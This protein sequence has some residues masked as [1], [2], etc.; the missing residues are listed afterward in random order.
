LSDEPTRALDPALALLEFDSIALGIVAADAMVKASPIGTIYGGTVQPGKYLVLISGDTASVEEALAVGIDRGGG[1]LVDSMFLPD[2]HPAVTA[3]VVSAVPGADF[4]GEALGI[5]ETSTVAAV[6]ASS[7]AGVKA[8]AV[9][10]IAVRMAD[11][12][13]GKGYALYSGPIAEVEAALEAASA[14]AG[15]GGALLRGEIV[16]QLHDEIAL[17]LAAELRFGPRVR[18]HGEEGG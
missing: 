8:A 14:V 13:G 15:E 11:G 7:D 16:A 1:S 12:L 2:V 10:L 5:V 17:N 4:T 18:A 3:S 6:L 9:D